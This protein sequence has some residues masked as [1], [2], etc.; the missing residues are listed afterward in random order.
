MQ[1]ALLGTFA[2]IALFF[3]TPKSQAQT[4]VSQ[5]IATYYNDKWVGKP[6]SSG[7]LLD[8]TS[9]T[10]AHSSYP[11][12]TLLRIT[13]LSTEQAIVVRV[14]DKQPK[15]SVFIATVTRRGAEIL[16][17]VAVGGKLPVSVE[18]VEGM[19]VGKWE[20]SATTAVNADFNIDKIPQAVSIADMPPPS[21]VANGTS[22][23]AQSALTQAIPPPPVAIPAATPIAFRK[24]GAK[25]LTTNRSANPLEAEK[26]TAQ[27]A[28]KITAQP[29]QKI[30]AQ[31][32]AK[33]LNEPAQKMAAPLR[34]KANEDPSFQL[35]TVHHSEANVTP[36]GFAIQMGAMDT[37]EKAI[38]L[39]TKLNNQDKIDNVLIT[40]KTDATTNYYKVLV[41]PFADASIA[42]QYREACKQN[43]VDCFVVDLVTM[44][45]VQ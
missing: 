45:P 44:M 22:S 20:P 38:E 33:P 13:N 19:P 8:K 40:S 6:T 15:T 11:L 41:G 37:Y 10:C 16:G 31:A 42:K 1:P 9:F 28:E 4:S 18:M 2:A 36:S 14:N 26:I 32:A 17:M 43:N 7:E 25:T 24:M 23:G 39:V 29:V 27:P 12:G 30:T 3:Y 34:I 35:K 21:A 5:G